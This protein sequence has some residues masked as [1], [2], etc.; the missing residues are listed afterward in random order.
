MSGDEGRVLRKIERFED[1]LSVGRSEDAALS[2][3][4]HCDRAHVFGKCKTHFP[5][6]DRM[7]ELI[8]DKTAFEQNQRNRSGDN[9]RQIEE[10]PCNNVF[11]E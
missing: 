7:F 4:Y 9:V 8:C 2:N 1:K 10:K 3:S 11:D 6:T 5:K